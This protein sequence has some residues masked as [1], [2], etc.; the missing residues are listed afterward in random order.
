MVGKIITVDF[1]GITQ[2]E[3]NNDSL[4]FPTVVGYPECVR[5]DKD[6]IED[7]NIDL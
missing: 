3:N 6:G 2:D 7:T 4:R 1:R 5:F